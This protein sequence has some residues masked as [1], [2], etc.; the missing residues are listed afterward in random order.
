[1]I[2]SAKLKN[3]P[4]IKHG[5]LLPGQNNDAIYTAHQVHEASWLWLT[6]NQK[7]PT[8]KYKVDAIGTSAAM[9]AV[10]VYSADCVPILAA[11]LG[12]D[13]QAL[14]VIAIHA[15]WRG[16]AQRIAHRVIH[17]WLGVVAQTQPVNRL[18]AAIGP[19][20]RQAAFEVGPEIPEAFP[21]A[22]RAMFSKFLK[23]E[24]N[25]DKFLFDL[26]GA[27]SAQLSS[28][29]LQKSIALEIDIMPQCTFS[30]TSLPSYRRD[31][32]GAGRILSMISLTL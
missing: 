13:D 11:A 23:R 32:K 9:L 21:E 29:A 6:D 26:V 1:M 17:S 27:N 7:I 3:I 25:R 30:D 18:V 19:C 14:A 24:N 8:V 16:T 10:G 4:N 12:N 22:E 20:I 15:G 5:F 31:G 2:H 28:A